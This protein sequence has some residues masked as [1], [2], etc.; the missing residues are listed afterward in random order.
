[1]CEGPLAKA[2]IAL[3]FL[4]AEALL[5]RESEGEYATRS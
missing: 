5:D 2:P 4:G 1:M 3:A